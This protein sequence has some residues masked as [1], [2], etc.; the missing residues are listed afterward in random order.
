[1]I[2]IDPQ[3]PVGQVRLI[4]GDSIEPYI[5]SDEVIEFLLE[6]ADGDI[7]KAAKMA[8]QFVIRSL[9]KAVD[10]S[11]GDISIKYSQMLANFRAIQDD[12]DRKSN[13]SVP[14]FG[15]TT[16]SEVERVRQSPESVGLF[17]RGYFSDYNDEGRVSCLNPFFLRR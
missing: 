8:L 1:M 17:P 2:D 11:V 12:L 16:R 7:M 4:I 15:G 10:Q 6:Q 9:T 14:I 13:L 5:I 3:S